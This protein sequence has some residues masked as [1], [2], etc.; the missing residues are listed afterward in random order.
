MNKKEIKSK[1]VVS[2]KTFDEF[3]FN[4]LRLVLSDEFARN[5]LPEEESDY[6]ERAI[7]RCIDANVP[8]HSEANT[9]TNMVRRTL[10]VINPRNG[11]EMKWFMSGGTDSA[12]SISYRDEETGDEVRITLSSDAISVN[13]KEDENK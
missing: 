12:M 3:N 9:I 10:K 11:N 2:E 5:E 8:F 1:L 4:P 6:R 7:N 13:P